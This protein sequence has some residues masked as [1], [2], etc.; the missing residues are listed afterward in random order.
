MRDDNK[1]PPFCNLSFCTSELN[2]P[3]TITRMFSP[4]DWMKPNLR[5]SQGPREQLERVGKERAFDCQRR[6]SCKCT[7]LQRIFSLE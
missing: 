6:H 2:T 1:Y 7:V 4:Y 3:G 5:V